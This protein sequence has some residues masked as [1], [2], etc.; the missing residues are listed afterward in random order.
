MED[1]SNKE[2]QPIYKVLRDLVDLYK[3]KSYL[4]IGVQEGDSLVAV[5]SAGTIEKLVLCDT[6]GG[7]YGGTDRGDHEHIVDILSIFPNWGSCDFLDGDSK[8][9]IP[10]LNGQLDEQFDLITVDGDHSILGCL[11]DMEN[12]WPLLKPGGNMV[13]DDLKHPAHLYIDNLIFAFLKA[14][15]DGALSVINHDGHGVAVLTKEA[16]EDE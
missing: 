1:I 4:E 12:A 10:S 5:L 7:E 11:T 16:A 15:L 8:E 9:L 6:W 13:I 3:P 2:E 14:H